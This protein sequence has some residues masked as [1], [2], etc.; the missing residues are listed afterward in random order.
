[1]YQILNYGKTKLWKAM[2]NCMHGYILSEQITIAEYLTL[3][4]VLL[5]F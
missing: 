1:M 5:H 3:I 4:P 2:C